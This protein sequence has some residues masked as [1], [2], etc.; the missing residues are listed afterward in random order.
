MET[1]KGKE[2]VISRLL[3]ASIPTSIPVAGVGKVEVLCLIMRITTRAESWR[4]WTGE[5]AS[6]GSGFAIFAVTRG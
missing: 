5:S 6:L 3:P 4:E 1:G 2:L